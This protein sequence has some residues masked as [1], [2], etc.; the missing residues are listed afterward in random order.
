M[1]YDRFDKV[2]MYFQEGEPLHT[3]ITYA[4]NLDQSLADGRYE[5]DGDMIYAVVASYETSPAEER[6][7]EAHKRYID[8]QVVFE[9]E[10]SIGVSLAKNLQVLEEYSDEHDVEFFESPETY[11]S[12]SM[13][14]GYFAVFYPHDIHRPNCDLLGTQN[15]RKVVIKVKI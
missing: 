9:G 4:A 15:A 5:I 11:S 8:V 13:K 7:F 6:R 1:I 2:T 12:L 3:A 14:P 10:E